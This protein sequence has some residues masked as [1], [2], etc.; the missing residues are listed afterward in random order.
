MHDAGNPPNDT[1]LLVATCNLLNL[2]NPGRIF[3]DNLEPYSERDYA[4]KVEWLGE[5]FQT[6][7]VDVLAV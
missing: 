3:Y 4:R 7:N 1:T 5:R 2:A 6:L